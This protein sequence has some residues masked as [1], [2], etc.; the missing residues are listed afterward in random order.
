M[1]IWG[2][3]L[4]GASVL[5][6]GA[7]AP[8]A[9]YSEADFATVAK[10]DAHVHA[11]VEDP[12]FLE[13][14]RRDRFEL[15]AINVDYPDFPPLGLQATVAHAMRADDP[16]RLRF[17]TTFS[18][19]GF[20]APGWSERTIRAIDAEV[21]KGAVAVK[22]WKNVVIWSSGSQQFLGSA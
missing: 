16:K 5:A 2:T 8:E 19:E 3:M 9:S 4:L 7:R 12:G 11:N 21:A 10:F 14:A 1:R 13:I 6:I 15:L 20:G 22:I 17:A 18:M